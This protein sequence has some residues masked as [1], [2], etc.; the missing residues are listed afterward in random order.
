V[1]LISG[2]MVLVILLIIA[3]A[4][5]HLT[6]RDVRSSQTVGDSLLTLYLAEAGLEY[7]MWLNKHNM[8]LYPSITYN[9]TPY[10]ISPG[11]I[12][13]LLVGD[14]GTAQERVLLNDLAFDDRF[15]ATDAWL[16]HNHHCGTFEV[17]QTV[18]Q[19]SGST[20]IWIVR[21]TSIGRVRQVPQDWSWE[22]EVLDRTDLASADWKV[23]S[24]RTL[25][26]EVRVDTS[27]G[28]LTTEPA[29]I[30]EARWYERFR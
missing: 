11:E 7:A 24:K 14:G 13:N 26:A 23:R 2:L 17:R 12:S 28:T 10:V 22:S 25:Y 29:E 9:D 30:E 3:S 20:N 27:T 18:Q 16:R 21:I 1:A 15:D 8:A 19:A 6:A 5:V 4:F